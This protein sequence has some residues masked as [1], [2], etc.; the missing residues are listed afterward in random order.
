MKTLINQ[1]FIHIADIGQHVHD[2]HYDLIGPGGEIILPQVWE[3][4]IKPD[5][6]IT[7]HL[8]PIPELSKPDPIMMPPPMLARMM[9]GPP[10]A[11]AVEKKKKPKKKPNPS[12][13]AFFFAGGSAPRKDS[14]SGRNVGS[15]GRGGVI[16][17]IVE[18][19]SPTAKVDSSLSPN[20]IAW[21]SSV[22]DQ[23]L[24]TS[25]LQTISSRQV[26]N[27]MQQ[28]ITHDLTTQKSALKDLIMQRFDKASALVSPPRPVPEMRDADSSNESLMRPAAQAPSASRQMSPP[29]VTTNR[30]GSGD[31][32]DKRRAG[33]EIKEPNAHSKRETP[34]SSAY[35]SVIENNH[36]L[37]KSFVCIHEGCG[38]SYTRAEH[39]D[40]HQFDHHP[41]II[42]H[43]DFPDCEHTFASQDSCARHKEGH[44]A[45]GSEPVNTPTLGS[46]STMVADTHSTSAVPK[47]TNWY[48]QAH[49]KYFQ[50]QSD[51]DRH[52]RS[53]RLHPESATVSQC[54]FCSQDIST[55]T[56][57]FVRHLTNK[58]QLSVQEAKKFVRQL[59]PKQSPE[60]TL[61]GV[62]SARS[63]YPDLQQRGSQQLFPVIHR[64]NHASIDSVSSKEGKRHSTA[65]RPFGDVYVPPISLTQ[66]HL[67]CGESAAPDYKS[68]IETNGNT[69]AATGTATP[70]EDR[71]CICN[72]VSYGAMIQCENNEVRGSVT[73]PRL[74]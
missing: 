37:D 8:W 68:E 17:E 6:C 40:R 36:E 32:V 1:A 59:R 34:Y 14:K 56:H 62:E 5:W 58:H 29:E 60:L 50:R 45:K 61:D 25:D 72:D 46:A 26:R 24:V 48:C 11:V 65:S 2:G 70:D 43:C 71:Y 51:L 41:S 19:S 63:P 16:E 12:P 57:N 54:P 9:A 15:K 28:V 20:E 21:Y 64:N 66:D 35:N 42:Y 18:I 22:I 10:V 67:V 73:A 27:Q 53:K 39:L 38:R 30:S 55:Y 47:R 13:L 69:L 23:I 7:M 49:D 44:I 33:A 4:E 3:F 52:L 31:I 74:D